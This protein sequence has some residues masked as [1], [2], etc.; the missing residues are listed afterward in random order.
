MLKFP[1]ITIKRIIVKTFGHNQFQARD[2]TVVLIKFATEHNVFV[3]AVCSLVICGD[4]TNQNCKSV[5][6]Q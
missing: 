6:K 5:P 3:E 4:L 2:V 1:V